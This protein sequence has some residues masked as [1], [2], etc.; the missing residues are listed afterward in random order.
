[1]NNYE[2]NIVIDA[3][4]TAAGKKAISEKIE[5]MI[6]LLKGELG[7]MQDFGEKAYG[8]LLMFPLKLGGAEAKSVLSKVKQDEE[9]IKHMMIKV[10]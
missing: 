4:S 9:I 10:K 3:K 8:I 6:K 7:E 5:K 2:L 1:M